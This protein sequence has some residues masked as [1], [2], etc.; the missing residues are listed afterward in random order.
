[1]GSGHFVDPVTTYRPELA[2][3]PDPRKRA[4]NFSGYC[5]REMDALFDKLETELDGAKRRELM[6]Q[7][8]VKKEQDQPLMPLVFVPR[9]FAMRDYVK[10]FT[11]DDEGAF[12]RSGGGLNYT[13]LDK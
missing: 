2:C 8:I 3:G 11:T 12:L 10:G 1:M 5:D 4:S 6:R 7:I 13:W 9:F